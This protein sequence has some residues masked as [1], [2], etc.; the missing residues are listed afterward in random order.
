[1]LHLLN[2][3]ACGAGAGLAPASVE[4]SAVATDSEAVELGVYISMPHDGAML[5]GI[6]RIQA[7]AEED[8]LVFNI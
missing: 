2:L 3:L 6:Q 5:S 8:S 1:M 4:D 7:K